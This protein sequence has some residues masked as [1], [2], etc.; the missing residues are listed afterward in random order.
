MPLW[1]HAWR[2]PDFVDQEWVLDP[3]WVYKPNYIETW[4]MNV[5]LLHNRNQHA[6]DVLM[7]TRLVQSTMRGMVLVLETCIFLIQKHKNSRALVD[8]GKRVWSRLTPKRDH[9]L[10]KINSYQST[11][12]Q[13]NKWTRIS[14][15]KKSEWVWTCLEHDFAIEICPKDSA[16]SQGFVISNWISAAFFPYPSPNLGLRDSIWRRNLFW[17][18]GNATALSIWPLIAR[19]G[20]F[21]QIKMRL[22]QNWWFTPCISMGVWGH[23]Q[24]RNATFLTVEGPPNIAIGATKL[25]S[26]SCGYV[27]SVEMGGFLEN[28]PMQN[29]F[30]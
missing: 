8:V 18:D 17:P 28:T 4:P 15:P 6:T 27:H 16:P 7:Y 10:G 21:N 25:D 20:G 5:K 22:C 11:I 30:F 29:M 26:K 23:T 2:K 12:W 13:Q 19:V 1:H 9:L 14:S 3:R 24:S